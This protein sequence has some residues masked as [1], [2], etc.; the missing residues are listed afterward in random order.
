[1]QN[2]KTEKGYELIRVNNDVNGNP[3]YVVHFLALLS[4]SENRN[5]MNIPERY[6]LALKKS[7]AY[8]GR[9]HHT[10]FVAGGI[11][12]QCYNTNELVNFINKCAE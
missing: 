9:K 12:F 5:G 10:K 7:R 4:D 8:G 2:M 3:R 1:M 11:V 6:A